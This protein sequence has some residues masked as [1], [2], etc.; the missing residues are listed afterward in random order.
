MKLLSG[1]VKF[2]IG[3]FLA[4]VLLSLVGVAATRYFM[5]RLTALPPKPAF[6][7]DTAETYGQPIEPEA[8]AAAPTQSE[9]P[10]AAPDAAPAQTEPQAAAPAEPAPE[11]ALEPGAYPARVIQPIGLILRSDPDIEAERIGGVEYEAELTVLGE[12][13][14]GDWL[15][16]RL[17]NDQEGWVK[18]GNTERL[19]SAAAE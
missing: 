12:S 2:T 7:N 18:A 1:L 3:V 15:Q 4:L 6:A 17:A 8:T 9:T 16:V 14:D 11:T 5:A 10:P 19:E 13:D